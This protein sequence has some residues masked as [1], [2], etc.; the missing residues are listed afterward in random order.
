MPH[1]NS[2]ELRRWTEAV[3]TLMGQAEEWAKK[4]GWRAVAQP[5]Q[6][7]EEGLGSYEV[8][9]LTIETPSGKIVLEPVAMRASP[10][11]G[12]VDVYA[13][14]SLNRLMLVRNHETWELLTE[15]GVRW[16]QP[17]EPATLSYLASNLNAAA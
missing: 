17:W 11:E 3:R 7:T 14:P 6:L 15:A 16:P 1:S 13:W 9:L 2:D 4:Q 8:P 10:G 5:I 12:R